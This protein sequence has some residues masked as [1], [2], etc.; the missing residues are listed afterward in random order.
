MDSTKRF[1]Q[2][3][4]VGLGA[5]D[6]RLRSC[7]DLLRSTVDLAAS[8]RTSLDDNETENWTSF[9]SI[10]NAFRNI[11]IVVKPDSKTE[12]RCYQALLLMSAES[13]VS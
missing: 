9:D 6:D 7:V 10:L 1:R 13:E 12:K 5:V 8:V 2:S 3:Y 11:C 4:T